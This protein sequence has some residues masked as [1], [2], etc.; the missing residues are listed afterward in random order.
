LEPGEAIAYEATIVNDGTTVAEDLTLVLH[1]DD[2]MEDLAVHNGEETCKRKDHRVALGSL[3][4]QEPLTLSISGRV[5][6]PIPDGAELRFGASVSAAECAPFE[7]DEIVTLVRARPRF[8]QAS[9]FLRMS[10]HDR[11]RPDRV[12]TVAVNVRNEGNDRAQD[13]RVAL[14]HS[15]ELRLETVEG[16]TRDG[17]QILFGDVDAGQSR[18]A[19]V[20]L[21]LVHVVPRG[22]TIDVHGVIVGR[23]LAP[24]VLDTVVIQTYAEANFSEAGSFV[25]QPRDAVDAGAELSHALV[26]RNTGDGT[27]KTLAV[28]V[29]RP[30][31]ITYVPG[32]TSINGRALLDHSG[33][34]LL[35]SE[36]GLVLNEIA[37]GVEIHVQW[38]SIVN[39]P[40]PPGTIVQA[41][42]SISY[43]H[44]SAYDIECAPVVVRSAAIFSIAANDLPF[45]IAS[46][47][48]LSTVHAES[49]PP[50]ELPMR[51]V[52]PLPAQNR[53][54]AGTYFELPESIVPPLHLVTEFSQERLDRTLRFL[55][56]TDFRSLLTHFL[57][58]RAFFP[59]I[60]D[61]SPHLD[62][63]LEETR[64]ALR[65]TLDRLFTYVRPER[66]EISVEHLEN[67]PSR[68]AVTRLFVG[69]GKEVPMSIAPQRSGIVRIVRRK[70]W[71]KL[72]RNLRWEAPCPGTPSRIC[73]GKPWS[74][75]AFMPGT[76][77]RIAT[78]LSKR[79]KV[80]SPCRSACFITRRRL[81]VSRSWK[82][83]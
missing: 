51:R 81:N 23:G 19:A 74:T 63:L 47:P 9:S 58:L 10:S 80:S 55:K 8:T 17:S 26:L 83:R 4:P 2:R 41:K 30:D 22:F 61:G 57:V 43:D 73:W 46:I 44:V 37:P 28:K 20:Q 67:A 13:V 5:C 82:R 31:P 71:R 38:F 53:T 34:S 36:Q 79:S 50:A 65:E 15:P 64:G 49:A 12:C 24:M 76:S 72:L 77:A 35:W 40:L 68:E 75:T 52:S 33:T 66:L 21:R 11:L 42:A 18:E 39:A 16:A 48:A 60:A 27:A 78:R 32:S 3:E 1:A 54:V 70:R 29:K 14:R 25:S 6:S 62:T 7:L 45:A 59:G 69:L 56:G